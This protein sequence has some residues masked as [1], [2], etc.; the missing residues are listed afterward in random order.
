MI[1]L[2]QDGREIPIPMMDHSHLINTIAKELRDFRP[3]Y[4]SYNTGKKND[5][6][7][8]DDALELHGCRQI[9]I[10]Q[11]KINFEMLNENLSPYM[12]ELCY[13]LITKAFTTDEYEK[14]KHIATMLTKYGLRGEIKE[15]P[16]HYAS[17][18]AEAILEQL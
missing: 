2:T 15:L 9:T 11:Y 17:G 6:S 1:H 7:I 8:S 10:K 5:K 3:V 12:S 16:A 4:E 14:V 18:D 13:R